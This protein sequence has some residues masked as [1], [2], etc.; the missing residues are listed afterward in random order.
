[1]PSNGSAG[2]ASKNPLRALSLKQVVELTNLSRPYIYSLISKGLFPA[3]AKIGRRSIWDQ[4]EVKGWLEVRFAR[5][6][7]AAASDAAPD[8]R[9]KR[10]GRSFA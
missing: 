6:V 3:P 7:P 10:S 8:R 5:R 1:M 4:R 9:R 2:T